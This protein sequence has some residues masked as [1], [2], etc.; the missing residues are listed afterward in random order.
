MQ[1]E[2]YKFGVH[3]ESA[4]ILNGFAKIARPSLSALFT[5]ALK[6][7]PRRVD[8]HETFIQCDGNVTAGSNR[9]P[10]AVLPLEH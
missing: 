7:L 5:I 3:I 4:S 10:F 8:Q 6:R 1:I 9:H 2:K